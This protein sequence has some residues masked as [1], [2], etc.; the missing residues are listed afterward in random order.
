M[1]FLIEKCK[2]YAKYIYKL[3]I[4]SQSCIYLSKYQK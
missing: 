2:G 1:N 4:L 3:Y